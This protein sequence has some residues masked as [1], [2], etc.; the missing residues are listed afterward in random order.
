[1]QQVAQFVIFSGD[2][3]GAANAPYSILWLKA[4]GVRA[5]A[6]SGPHS[7]EYWRP[8][9]HPTKF[10]GVLPVL[11][12]EDDTTIYSV[13]SSPSLAHAMRPESLAP[14]KHTAAPDDEALRRYVAALERPSSSASFEWRGANQAAIG[15]R[16]EPGEV[17]STQVTYDRGWRASVNGAP[18]AVYRDGFGFLAVRANCAGDCRVDLV[19]DGGLEA[20]LCRTVSLAALLLSCA[21][22][23][24]WPRRNSR[25]P[26]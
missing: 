23:V 17:V 25:Q 10:D 6:V 22:A 16:L 4:F 18:R 11:W 5:I 20:N 1:M 24:G 9:G 15:A 12:H 19:Y 8:F 2:A 26:A 13:P 3:S 7:P 14:S 21:F